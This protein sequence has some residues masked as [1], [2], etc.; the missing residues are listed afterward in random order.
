MFKIMQIITSFKNNKEIKEDMMNHSIQ[1][2]NVTYSILVKLYN[3]QYQNNTEK[4]ITATDYDPVAGTF[5]NT[6]DSKLFYSQEDLTELGLYS[7]GS[8]S[9]KFVS[10]KDTSKFEDAETYSNTIVSGDKYYLYIIL[11]KDASAVEWEDYLNDAKYYEL[12]IYTAKKEELLEGQVSATYAKNKVSEL[13]NNAK[14]VIF[15]ETLETNYMNNYKSDYKAT[16]KSSKTVVASFELNGNTV[17]ITVDQLWAKLGEFYGVYTT[18]DL[19][20]YEWV[21]MEATDSQGELL[22]KYVDYQ[23][24]LSGK[25]LKKCIKDN[26]DAK[27]LYENVCAYVENVKY[28]FSVGSY[29]SSGYPASYGWKNFINDYYATY[30]NVKLESNDDLRL[31]FINQQIISDYSADLCK[32]TEAKWNEA[33]LTNAGK[34]LGN[35]INASGVHLLIALPDAEKNAESGSNNNFVDP[36]NW[37]AQQLS[38]AEEVYDYVLNM[39]SNIDESE[40]SSV[41]TGIANAFEEAP[42]PLADGTTPNISYTTSSMDESSTTTH[43]YFTYNYEYYK[44]GE[45]TPSYVINVSELKAMGFMLTCENLDVTAGA[46]V[47]EFEEAVRQIWNKSL[48]K[49]VKD[50]TVE[51]TVIYDHSFIAPKYKNY[52]EDTDTETVVND[53]AGDTYLTTTYGL[54]VYVNQSCDLSAYFTT[55]ANNDKVFIAI[56]E[57]EYA[58]M[59]VYDLNLNADPKFV[60]LSELYK[61]LTEA[62]EENDEYRLGVAKE[63]IKYASEKLGIDENKFNELLENYAGDNAGYVATQLKTYFTSYDSENSEYSLCFADYK[64]SSYY[65]LQ[66]MNALLAGVSSK[67]TINSDDAE[68]KEK[69]TSYINYFIKSY[70]NSFKTINFL[71]GSKEACEDLLDALAGLDGNVAYQTVASDAMNA[72]KACAS[73]AYNKLTS[74][75]KSELLTK[76]A[77]AG[78]VS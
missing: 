52:D 64:G 30:Y 63:N 60:S 6:V 13:R 10:F 12:P 18:V 42:L 68:A 15:D 76:A 73:Q 31:F 27:K 50:A 71:S 39:I 57:V 40:I 66:Y 11:G 21:F 75:E 69:F 9:N 2:S 7:S 35:Y 37:T 62:K 77:K 24:Y 34:T 28:Y 67:I 51:E 4:Q 55:D 8:S 32:V 59:Y 74:E 54:H 46:M 47:P 17:E 45:T 16:K 72:L 23:K 78:I 19:L 48:D 26:D 43:N 1:L 5:D 44:E 14:L 49:L 36:T 3:Q 58:Q 53:N 25:K 22:N 70:N 29:E 56:P 41:L 61:D 38:K 65:H 33:Y 20:Q